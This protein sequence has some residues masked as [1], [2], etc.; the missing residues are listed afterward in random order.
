MAKA[1]TS[2]QFL[3]QLHRWGIKY[4]I[5]FKD[6]ATHNRGDRGNGWG[7]MHGIVQHHTG[8]DN[9]TPEYLYHGSVE[10]PGPLCHV[11]NDVNGMLH[12]IGWGRT[13]HAGGGD[14]NV[15]HHVM[16]E[17]YGQHILV[18]QFGEG[19]ADAYDGNG[20]FYG[21]ENIYSG[22]HAMSEKQ[23]HT[24]VLFSA[25]ICEFHQWSEL[26]VIGHGEWSDQ[27]RDPSINGKKMMDMVAFR[28]SVATALDAG[29][30]RH[31]DPIPSIPKF[32]GV[33]VPGMTSKSVTLLDEQLIKIG[34]RHYYNSGPG[35]YFGKGTSAAVKAFM[36]KHKELWMYGKPDSTVGPATWHAIFSTKA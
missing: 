14:V 26:S 25:A 32:P 4:T 24:A 16:Q 13:N 8:A 22:S 21:I 34:Y 20:V 29:P 31:P 11:G 27:K 19:D 15:L 7:N 36:Q 1:M 6:W 28:R 10:L 18:P 35:P 9:T 2:T 30:I 3:A 17:D 12:L 33:L 5:S 23:L